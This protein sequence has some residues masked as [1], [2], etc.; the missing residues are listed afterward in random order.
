MNALKTCHESLHKVVQHL[1]GFGFL[2]IIEKEGAVNNFKYGPLGELLFENL[3]REWIF[4]NT[5]KREHNVFNFSCGSQ[6]SLIK[7][8]D[9]VFKIIKNLTNCEV[10]FSLAETRLCEKEPSELPSLL[11]Q[12][13]TVARLLGFFGPQDAEQYFYSWIQERKRW[14]RLFSLDPGKFS[15]GQVEKVEEGDYEE[16]KILAKFPWGDHCLETIRFLRDVP[17]KHLS[18][19]EQNKFVV[20][21]TNKRSLPYVIESMSSF[22]AGVFTYFCDAFQMKKANRPVCMFHRKLAPYKFSFASGP[23]FNKKLLDIARYL[24][25]GLR[26]EG[27][28]TLLPCVDFG[29]KQLDQQFAR[30]DA[31]GVPYTAVLRPEALERGIFGLRSRD[32]TLEEEVHVG[33]FIE[34]GQLLMKNY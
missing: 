14:W 16:S 9:H 25:L 30:F 22:D 1:E 27:V 2:K 10:P 23:P 3:R 7:D 17:F 26:K 31:L 20:M 18:N 8:T 4:S 5:L 33:T 13:H 32:T 12:N 34:Y 24:G 21:T 11:P 6:E 15:F 19:A 29:K 28:V